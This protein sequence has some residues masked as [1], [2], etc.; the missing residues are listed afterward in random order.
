MKNVEHTGKLD[1]ACGDNKKEGFFG[2][3]KFKTA[4]TDA[5]FDLLEFPWPIADA[6][7]D[8]ANCSHFF[9][10][11]PKE[12]RPLFMEELFRVLKN[13]AKATLI[14]PMGDRMFQDFTHEWPPVIPASY[15][16]FNKEWR[17]NNKLEHGPYALKC[18][19][20]YSYG[21]GLDPYVAGFNPERQQFALK[22]HNN[23]ATD[24]YVTVVKRGAVSV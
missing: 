10:H 17:T 1:L 21:Y 9:E 22:F 6:S 15:L 3:D 24:L 14:T 19:F 13:G 12:K 20:D 23:A 8:E 4:S 11:I 7:V 16:Y 18:D 5:T 2:I